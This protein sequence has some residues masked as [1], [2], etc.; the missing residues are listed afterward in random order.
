MSEEKNFYY[1][2]DTVKNLREQLSRAFTIII[3]YKNRVDILKKEKK[4]L[5]DQLNYVEKELK[6]WTEE[7]FKK[8]ADLYTKK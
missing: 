5:E 4:F 6:I 7:Y 2:I 1:Y 3:Y 8:R